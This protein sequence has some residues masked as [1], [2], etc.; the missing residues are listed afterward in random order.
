M[1]GLLVKYKLCLKYLRNSDNYLN[2]GCCM[3]EIFSFGKVPYGRLT[4][5]HF[6][7]QQITSGKFI[8]KL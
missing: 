4:A 2:L 8:C 6:A 5:N 1:F 7:A 3:Y